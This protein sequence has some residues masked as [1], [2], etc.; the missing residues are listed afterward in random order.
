M[1]IKKS[2]IQI[3]KEMFDFLKEHPEYKQLIEKMTNT[4]IYGKEG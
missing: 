1:K 3:L 2:N 4:R